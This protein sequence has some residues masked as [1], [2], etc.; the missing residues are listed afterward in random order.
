[1]ALIALHGRWHFAFLKGKDKEVLDTLNFM[2][3]SRAEEMKRNSFSRAEWIPYELCT[4]NLQ[5]ELREKILLEA[6]EYQ[7]LLEKDLCNIV[8]GFTSDTL[9]TVPN[10]AD[11]INA[12]VEALI[13]CMKEGQ[14]GIYLKFKS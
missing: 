9:R 3:E 2:N 6:K 8:V 1:M 11:T 12:L 5:Q 4:E 14:N 7:A 10:D 13:D